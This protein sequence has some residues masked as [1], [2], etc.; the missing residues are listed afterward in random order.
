MTMGHLQVKYMMHQMHMPGLHVTHHTADHL[1]HDERFWR[2]VHMLA[3][4]AVL[5]LFAFWSAVNAY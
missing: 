5:I 3:F 2:L 1:L 4:L